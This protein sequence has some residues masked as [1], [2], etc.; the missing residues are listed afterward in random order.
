MGLDMYLYKV[1]KLKDEEKANFKERKIT[2]ND[3]ESLYENYDITIE[4][5]DESP[6]AA[7]IK[8]CGT[9]VEYEEERFNA[10]NM[11]KKY[12]PKLD[13][14]TIEDIGSEV[15]D[16]VY[17]IDFYVENSHKPVSLSLTKEQFMEFAT[18]YN[19]PAYIYSEEE[20]AYWR[21]ANQIRNWFVE[22]L[23]EP[24]ENCGNSTVTKENI[25]QLLEDCKRCL[26]NKDKAADIIPT[27]SG[28]FFGDTTY[29][30]YYYQQIENTAEKMESIL[31]DMDWE[32]NSLIYHEWW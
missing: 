14:S 5:E 4:K 26:A 20:V 17:C 28:F 15:K 25:E 23:E 18:V 16:G 8:K 27:S 21:K 11:V 9:K 2:P 13:Y 3:L 31:N 19:M 29:D 22:H 6:I 12:L 32:N 7:A 1:S 24:V 30:D 10:L